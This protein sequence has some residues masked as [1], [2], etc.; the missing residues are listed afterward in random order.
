MSSLDMSA[1]DLFI[2]RWR[3][4]TA[5]SL[6][7]PPQ[8]EN[9]VFYLIRKSKRAGRSRETISSLYWEML[10]ASGCLCPCGC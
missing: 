1:C 6:Y 4:A 8:R 7:F 10:L 5:D 9:Q 2:F 3:Q